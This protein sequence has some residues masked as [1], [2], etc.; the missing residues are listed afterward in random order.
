MF[1]SAWQL[2]LR[3]E[4]VVVAVAPDLPLKAR[5]LGSRE[6][7]SIEG[8]VRM[9]LAKTGSSLEPIYDV[10]KFRE[11]DP[12]VLEMDPTLAR[13]LLRWWPRVNLDRGLDLT[14]EHFRRELEERQTQAAKDLYGSY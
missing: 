6:T 9:V 12:T 2:P 3:A 8:V 7:I 5:H 1:W 13:T 10:A 14:I 11:G 4:V